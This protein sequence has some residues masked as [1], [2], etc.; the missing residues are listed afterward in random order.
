MPTAND[1]LHHWKSYREARKTLLAVVGCPDSNRDP[2]AEFSE[3]L[4]AALIGGRLPI[5]RVQKDYDI[6]GSDGQY[7]QVRYV[8]NPKGSWVNG[9]DVVFEG[10]TTH[11]AVVVIEDLR[12]VTAIIFPKDA[13]AETSGVLGKRHKNHDS[14]ISLTQ[15]NVRK[16]LA[17]HGR[18]EALGLGVYHL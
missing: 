2:L 8:A 14:M 9:H 11:Y 4:V 12:P 18:F 15:A 3:Q 1:L 10:V 5:S 17:E 7:V 16:I 6:I 13:I